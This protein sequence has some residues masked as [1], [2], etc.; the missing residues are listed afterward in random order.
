MDIHRRRKVYK[1]LH[2]FPPEALGGY[3]FPGLVSVNLVTFWM[4]AS[5]VQ[6]SLIP[7]KFFSC[8]QGSLAVHVFPAPFMNLS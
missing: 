8:R 4:A 2:S 5:S 3:L 6:S 1:K 7:R